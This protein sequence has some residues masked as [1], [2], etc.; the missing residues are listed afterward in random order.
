MSEG[1]I[2]SR[3]R[4]E[5]MVRRFWSFLLSPERVFRSWSIVWSILPSQV[6]GNTQKEWSRIELLKNRL[7]RSFVRRYFII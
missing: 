2:I 5:R 1:R 3:Q 6:P 7:V 4:S